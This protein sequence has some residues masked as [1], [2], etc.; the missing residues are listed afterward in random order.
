MY[1]QCIILTIKMVLLSI[2]QK[3]QT[4]VRDY[5]MSLRS[6][7]RHRRRRTPPC[8]SFA[9]QNITI[10]NCFRVAGNIMHH[11]NCVYASEM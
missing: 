7:I 8:S 1:I 6:V 3:H 10:A 5:K 11:N 4:N 2:E 9:E